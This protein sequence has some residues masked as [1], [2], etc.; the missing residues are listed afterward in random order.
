[1]NNSTQPLL[2]EQLSPIKHFKSKYQFESG[3]T[4]LDVVRSTLLAGIVG[5]T[6]YGESVEAKRGNYLIGCSLKSSW[7]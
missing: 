3:S 2:K 6:S 7:L 5:K 1:M 4:K